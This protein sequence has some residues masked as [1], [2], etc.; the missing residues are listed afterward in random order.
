M[1][2]ILYRIIDAN[3]NRAREAFRVM[4]EYC[5][6]GLNNPSLSGQA[7]RCR[8][9]LCDALNSISQVTLVS[10]RDVEGDVGK[11]LKVEGQLQ[12]KSLQDC[13]TA[14]VKR[15]G[16]ALRALAETTQAID[17]TIA[18]TMEKLRFEVYSLEKNAILF[19]CSKQKFESV[20]LYVLINATP[21]KAPSEVIRLAKSCIENGADC[22]QLRA[23]GLCDSDFL[24]IAQNVVALCK[25]DGVVS[26]IN[27]R[28]DIAILSGADGV[29]LGQ[30]EIPVS[31]AKKLIRQPFIIGV[32]THNPDELHN[33]IKSGCDYVGIGPAFPSP[34][35]PSLEVAGLD[36]LQQALA[37]LEGTGIFH[38]AIG[39]IHSNNVSELLRIGVR[40]I[41][42]SSDIESSEDPQ[43]SCKTLKNRLLSFQK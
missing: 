16:E 15:A 22:I 20:R 19:A 23:K 10:N 30:N 42:V 9:Q 4:E 26:I 18:M 33:A 25:N 32:S 43:K 13:F 8:H 40:A 5:R 14:A 2:E 29:H 28:I 31:S 1:S 27:D 17:P 41:A 35:K 39:G 38:V 21:E 7:K 11:E 34:T 3:Y 24:N 6:F 12:R 36:Y 37:T